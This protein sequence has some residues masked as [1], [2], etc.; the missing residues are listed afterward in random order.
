[1]VQDL[2]LGLIELHE[3]PMGLKVP[4]DDIPLPQLHSSAQPHPQR[5]HLIPLYAPLMKTWDNT[6]PSMDL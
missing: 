3:V 2:A 1:M 4:L 5:V 6:G